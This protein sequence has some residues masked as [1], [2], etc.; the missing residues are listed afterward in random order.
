MKISGVYGL[1]NKLN[2]KWYVGVSKDI[3]KRWYKAYE[4]M[5]C[6]K[7]LKIYNALKKYGYENFE[8][9]ILEEC[10]RPMFKERETYW[11]SKYDSVDNGYN[12]IHGSA[13]GERPLGIRMS[14]ETKRKIG[15]ANRGH[16]HT[17]DA[18]RRMSES[19]RGKPKPEG[20]GEKVAEALRGVKHTDERRR[21][22]SQSLVG[23]PKWS[24]EDKRKMSEARTGKMHPRWK[25][26]ADENQ[27]F[28]R[29]NYESQ[30]MNWILNRLPVKMSQRK[31]QRCIANLR[32]D[33][34]ATIVA[35]FV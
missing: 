27:R 33:P 26:V 15:D 13:S 10:D 20:F 35:D 4:L 29:D 23:K 22:I 5:Q 34:S 8:K 30:T 17:D 6:K 1:R 28:I 11:I 9:I 24:E 3:T 16:R 18:R 21:N 25:P 12:I 2:G 32:R 31:L 7:Q 19:R 14:E